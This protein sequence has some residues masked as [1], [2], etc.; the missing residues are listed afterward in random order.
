ME[1]ESSDSTQ[2]SYIPASRP[3]MRMKQMSRQL[4]L[5]FDDSPVEEDETSR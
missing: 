1:P 5:Y 2:G 3:G 4:N